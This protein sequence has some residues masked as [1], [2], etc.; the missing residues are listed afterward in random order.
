ATVIS[1]L[2]AFW[3]SKLT[4]RE[5]AQPI[6]SLRHAAL[7]I[8]TG[9]RVPPLETEPTMKFS[10]VFTA[11]RRMAADLHTSRTELEKAQRRT[12][13]VLQNVASDVVAVDPDRQMSLANPRA[14][15]LLGSPLP[16][17]TSFAATAP[18]PLADVVQRFLMSDVEDE[19]AELAT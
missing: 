8:A 16:P 12:S 14:E 2:A 4:T 6:G 17:G 18:R 3:L 19:H 9:S 11:F 5:L 7:A 13:T 15:Q 10:P 1:T